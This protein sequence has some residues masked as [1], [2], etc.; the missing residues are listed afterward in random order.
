[1]AQRRIEISPCTDLLSHLDGWA[2]DDLMELFTYRVHEARRPK[3]VRTAMMNE[4]VCVHACVWRWEQ[5][6]EVAN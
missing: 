6:D 1:M 2:R 3:K 4:R 5:R